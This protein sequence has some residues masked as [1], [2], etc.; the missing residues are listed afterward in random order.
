MRPLLALLLLAAATGARAATL[1]VGPISLD[2]LPL[3]SQFP[4][5]LEAHPADGDRSFAARSEGGPCAQSGPGIVELRSAPGEALVGL[6]APY[7]LPGNLN[8]SESSPFFTPRVGGFSLEPLPGPTRGWITT[9]ACE[10]AVPF[11]YATHAGLA[12]SYLGQA[13]MA[14]PTRHTISGSFTRYQASGTG[15]AETSFKTNFT[16]AALRVGNRLVVATSNFHQAGANPVFHPGTVLL[17]D[18]DD[19]VNPPSVAPAVPF[20]LLTSDPNPIALTALAGG[21]VLVTN[22]GIHDAA[23]PPLV[24]GQGSIDVLDPG[25]GKLVASIPLGS[26]N[27]GGRSL[28]LDPSGSVA[29][30]GSQTLRQLFAIDVRGLEALPVAGIDPGLQRPSCNATSAA[31]AGGLPCLRARVIR[32]GA[33]PLALPP[34]PGTSGAY[35]LVPQVRFAASGAFAVATSFNDGGLALVAFDGRNLDRPHPLLPSRLG[36][37]QTLAATGPAGAIG[38]ECCPG[39]FVLRPGPAGTLDGSQVLFATATPNGLVVRGTLG[40][41]PLPIPTGDFDGDATEDALD[42]CPV[43]ADASQADRGRLGGTA[44]DGI[45]DACQCGDASDDGRVDAADVSA[46]RAFLAG[47]VAALAAPQKCDVGGSAA[48]DLVDRVRLSRALAGHA[49]GIA[50]ACAPFN[51]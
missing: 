31:S 30:A 26:G 40:G 36:S 20:A 27:P 16:S 25:A 44:P 14:V 49:P 46:L 43:T 35:S 41:A 24:T 2:T 29:L 21:R 28:A 22:A 6:G 34:P 4:P 7:L 11:D 23:F 9:S 38:E 48:C 17:F 39:A 13:R 19:S 12:I 42:V 18:L 51:P 1:S 45:G 15:A 5:A 37:A 8:C 3:C 50:H 10:L 47:A 33:N 32:G